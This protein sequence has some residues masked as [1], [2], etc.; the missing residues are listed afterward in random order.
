MSKQQDDFK[1]L[2]E[3][4][5]SAG[6]GII[7]ANKEGV[8]KFTNP[9]AESIFKYNQDELLD[10]KIEVLLPDALKDQ[11]VNHRKFYMAHPKARPMGQGLDLMGQCKDGSIVPVEISLSAFTFKGEMFVIS[12]II[13]ISKRKRQEAEIEASREQ[14][15]QHAENLEI[16]VKERTRELEHLNLGL[17]SQIQERR[18]AED[19]LKESQKLYQAIARNFPN[20][21]INVLDKHLKY[22]FIDGS[23]KSRLPDNPEKLLNSSYLDRFPDRVK[24]QVH[25]YLRQIGKGD[26]DPIE[27]DLHDKH[28]RLRGT[29]ISKE[30]ILVV[31][32]DIT[33]AKRVERE[34]IKS[35]ERERELNELKSRFVSMA[36]HEFRTPLSTILSSASLIS[37]YEE[38]AQQEKREKHVNK[39]KS[40]VQ[41][42]TNILNNFLSIEKVERGQVQAE[43]QEVL[44]TAIVNE[45]VEEIKDVLKTG[46]EIE[47]QYEI[48]KK[49]IQSDPKLLKNILINLL[50]NASKYSSED[51]KIILRVKTSRDKL[52]I[53]VQDFGIGIPEREQKNLFQAFYRAENVTNIQGTGLGLN[54]V[55]KYVDLLQ[56]RIKFISEEFKGTTFIIITPI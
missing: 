52:T 45:T 30:Q 28:Y 51:Q 23:L 33:S 22:I 20:G 44:I 25:E 9:R 43:I 14:L 2:R 34:I 12:F 55:K 35:L 10:Q 17:E 21:I 54:I 6:E 18:M 5:A 13:D 7:L 37:R 53:E 48:S 8:I 39:I 19:A 46:Q 24:S 32:E 49:T 16:R 36:S 1:L 31:E 15:K 47:V 3:I 29:P 50:S 4:F 42:L 38:P 56:G 11:H 41:N 26:L 27:I 40:S